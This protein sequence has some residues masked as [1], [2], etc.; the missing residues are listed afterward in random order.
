MNTGV[1]KISYNLVPNRISIFRRRF[2]IFP[3]EMY[4]WVII[5]CFDVLRPKIVT[6]S[7]KQK[8]YRSL[9]LLSHYCQARRRISIFTLK[10]KQFRILACVA[11]LCMLW[12]VASPALFA[13]IFY[14]IHFS[15]VMLSWA[16][17]HRGETTSSPSYKQKNCINTKTKQETFSFIFSFVQDSAE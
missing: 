14:S 6:M 17:R 3:L 13:D 10:G 9:C 5:K 4:V 15:W 1:Y 7:H 11:L 2:F 16:G 12:L 8:T